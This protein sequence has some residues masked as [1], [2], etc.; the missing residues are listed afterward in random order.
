MNSH[1]VKKAPHEVFCLTENL[2]EAC[3]TIVLSD[4]APGLEKVKETLKLS[5]AVNMDSPGKEFT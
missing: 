1:L 3:S 5:K 4:P 2:K